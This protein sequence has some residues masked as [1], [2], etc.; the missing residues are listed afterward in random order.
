MPIEAFHLESP[1]PW[2]DIGE[3][4]EVD[5]A[6][7][8]EVSLLVLDGGSQESRSKATVIGGQCH[9]KILEESENG[10]RHLRIEEKRVFFFL[11]WVRNWIQGF[12]NLQ[13]NGSSD[14]SL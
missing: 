13:G 7:C 11:I 3:G 10:R 8:E 12:P 4:G 9:W 14:K 2:E 5:L 6:P 1:R